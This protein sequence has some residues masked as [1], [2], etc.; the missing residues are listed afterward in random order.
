MYEAIRRPARPARGRSLALPILFCAVFIGAFLA[1][2][3]WAG[4]YQFRYRAFLTDLA[5]ATTQARHSGVY[6][7]LVDGQNVPLEEGTLSK[8]F[9]LISDAGSGRLGAPP[10]EG[11]KIV[12]D[13]GGPR[14]EIW[15]VPLTNPSNS[16]SDGP[17]FRYT[18]SAG[19]AYCYDTDQIAPYKL[20]RLFT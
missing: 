18:D 10:E 2:S 6:T 14:L 11:P 13:Y 15:I 19:K 16:W 17:F 1:L 5:D 8:L 7:V 3:I 20:L 12:V 4:R 9:L